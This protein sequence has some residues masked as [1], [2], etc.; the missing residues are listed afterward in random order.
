MKE[1]IEPTLSNI[2]DQIAALKGELAALER[3]KSSDVLDPQ[4]DRPIAEVTAQI[5]KLESQLP[6]LRKDKDWQR[7]QQARAEQNARVS[8]EPA[9][10]EQ[11]RRATERYQVAV[12]SSV[13][14]MLEALEALAKHRAICNE[15]NGH[16]NERNQGPLPLTQI[17]LRT[18]DLSVLEGYPS[19]AP[20]LRK[21]LMRP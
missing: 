7:E 2:V 12:L 16:R 10:R 1:K 11:A 6:A 21:E 17:H 5:T 14:A 20:A 18:V 3:M 8:R 13:D 9:L 19:A 4:F 15:I